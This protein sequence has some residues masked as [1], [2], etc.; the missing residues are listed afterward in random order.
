VDRVRPPA[1]GE[2]LGRHRSRRRRH[3]V[4]H[5]H[6]ARGGLLLALSR[7]QR[8]RRRGQPQGHRPTSAPSTRACSSSGWAPAP[9]RCCPTPP[10]SGASRWSHDAS[11]RRARPGRRRPATPV[12]LGMREYRFSVYRS[13]VPRRAP[14]PST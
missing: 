10:A 11:A 5:G 14:S 12:G 3:R 8:L 6:R 4:G 9:T 1:A 13:T 2:L 7:P